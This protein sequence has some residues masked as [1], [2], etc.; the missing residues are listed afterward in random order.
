MTVELPKVHVTIRSASPV[1]PWELDTE[2]VVGQSVSYLGLAYEC[3]QDH[4]SSA[5]LLPTNV[6]YWI[7]KVI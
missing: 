5:L 2:Y 7:L 6:L 1:V 4:V 3:I